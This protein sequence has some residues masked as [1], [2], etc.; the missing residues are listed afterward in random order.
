MLKKQ[1]KVKPQAKQAKVIHGEDDSITVY[2]KSP[3]IDGR[4]NQE[5]IQLLAKEFG[6][7]K[8]AVKILGGH[9]TRYKWVEIDGVNPS[10]A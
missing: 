3:P 2:L 6:V 8:S 1:V 5:L 10:L 7:P 4:A 9:T